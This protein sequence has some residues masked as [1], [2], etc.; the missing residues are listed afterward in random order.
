MSKEASAPAAQPA[1]IGRERILEVRVQQ[2]GVHWQG[3]RVVT[4]V[5]TD[6]SKV[7]IAGTGYVVAD[8][9]T[10]HPAGVLVKTKDG[11]FVI[12]HAR[13]EVSKLA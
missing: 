11:A 3:A 5:T 8:E 4:H 12:P 10:F 7:T 13:I 6:A 1:P 2:G 9:I